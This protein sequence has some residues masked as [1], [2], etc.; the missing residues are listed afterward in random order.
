MMPENINPFQQFKA[1]NNTGILFEEY[2]ES[3]TRAI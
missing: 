2:K 1:L 3:K